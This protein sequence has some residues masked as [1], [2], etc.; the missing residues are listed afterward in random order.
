MDGVIRVPCSIG[1]QGTTVVTKSNNN[2]S[3]S[4]T[5]VRHGSARAIHVPLVTV[6]CE[7]KV[8]QNVIDAISAEERCSFKVIVAGS[9]VNL[10][11]ILYGMLFYKAEHLAIGHDG[12]LEVVCVIDGD[13]PDEELDKRIK[14]THSGDMRPAIEKIMPEIRNSITGFTLG[15]VPQ[16]VVA[17][18]EYKHKTWLEEIS[19]SD[20]LS[21]FKPRLD[22][23]EKIL[24][25]CEDEKVIACANVELGL[26]KIEMAETLRII[27]T[28]RKVRLKFHKKTLPGTGEVIDACDYH[29]YYDNLVKVLKKGNS[30][31]IYPLHD[32]IYT[33]L[34]IMRKFNRRRW[35]AY[36][37]NVRARLLEANR[38]Q[39]E[40][41][42]KDRFNGV[43]I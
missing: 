22:E 2:D 26:L 23:L 33:V 3:S 29:K 8:A 37:E 30:L 43:T 21:K 4:L 32:P 7:D 35:L 36:T 31:Q 15:D 34:K 14:R 41:F 24:E 9:W 16:S 10:V 6:V 11:T 38:R 39:L 18:P 40:I 13:I 25:S 20:V 5:I 19:E 42:E 1:I 17:A 28:S 12:L 27:D